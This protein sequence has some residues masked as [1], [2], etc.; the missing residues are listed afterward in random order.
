MSDLTVFQHED[1][2][3]VVD[4]RLIAQEL[5]IEHESFMKTVDRYKNQAE[6]AFGFLRFE[7]GE[8]QGRGQPEKFVYLTEDQA[9]FLMTLSRN[10]PE[11]VRC[12]ILL[13]TQFSKAKKLLEEQGYKQVPHTSIYVKRLED[14]RDHI[15]EDHLW[16]VFREGAEVLLL[17]EKDFRVPVQQMDLCDGSIGRRWSDYRKDKGWALEKSTYT[18][19]FRDQRGDRLPAAYQLGELP[20]FRKW[21]RDEYIEK[22]LPEYLIE[23]YG[24]RAV[25]Q[26]YQEQD[27][28]DEYIISITEEKRPGAKQND[29]YEVFLAARDVLENRRLQSN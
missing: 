3:L 19:K 10:T 21:L 25:L 27:K 11:V 29:L 20:Y 6:Q 16:S 14:V 23:K 22:Y 12:K 24:K 18:H 2:Y 28:V 5:G 1:G 15:I 7:V 4:S 8:I 26:I 13:V 9:T 17:V